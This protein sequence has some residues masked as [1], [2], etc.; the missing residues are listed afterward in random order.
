MISPA[1][2]LRTRTLGLLLLSLQ[3]LYSTAVFAQAER[4][5]YSIEAGPLDQALSRFGVQAGISMAGSSTLTAGKRS[6][7]LHG[8]FS[9]EA[10]LAKLLA[11]TGLSFQ[12]QA[13]GSFE[14]HPATSAVVLPSQK[15]TGDDLEKK[16]VYTEPRSLVY[17]SNEEVRRFGVI[18][19]GDL[20][21][22]QPGVQVGDSRNGGGLDVNIRGIQGQSRVAVTVDGS[23]QALDVYR[24]YAGTQQRSY[25]DPDLISDVSIDKGPSLT[26][27]AIGGTVAI[28]TLGVDDILRDG[29]NVGLR[30]KGDLWNNGVE[31]ASRNSHSTTEDLYSEPHQNRGGLFGSDSESGSAAFAYTHDLFD[32]VAAYTHRNQGNYF[33]GKHGQD[34]YRTFDRYGQENMTVATTYNA[35]E[36]VL[37]SSAE[38]E[39]ILLKTTL[40]PADDHTFDFGYIRYDGRIGEIMPSDIFRFGTGGIYQY[41]RGST[42]IDTYTARY[43]YLPTGNMLVDLTTSLWMTDAKTSQLTSVLAPKSQ[44]YRSDR[45]WTRQDDR[46]IGGELANTSRF[47][48]RYGDFK[49]DLGGLV[50]ARGTAAAK[51]RGHHT[52]RYQRQ[53]QPA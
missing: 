7:G 36:E 39:S 17:I 42:K 21:K 50:P 24:G 15:V 22:G 30:L 47:D 31:P 18:S 53:P 9:T 4:Q 34:R 43:H 1:S 49:L 14:L 23:Q 26:S 41:P 48:T 19:A 2:V 51:E 25:I 3:P 16:A 5:P 46:R 12:R 35:G 52:E 13:D 11:G 45:N 44:A 29:K 6:N 40:R 20:L 10:G 37:N 32:V 8:D 33:S 27:S 28:R 38:T